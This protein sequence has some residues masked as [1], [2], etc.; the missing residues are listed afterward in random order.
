MTIALGIIATDGLVMAADTQQTIQGYAKFNRGKMGASLVSGLGRPNAHSG[1]VIAGAGTSAHL[2]ALSRNLQA[3]FNGPARLKSMEET[4]DA[5]AEVVEQ[6]HKR[7]VLPYAAFPDE[8]PDVKVLIGV[9]KDSNVKLFVSQGNLLKPADPYEAVGVGEVLAR[10][11]LQ[12][13]FQ[14]PMLDVWETVL[15]ASYVMYLVKESV[16]GC[17]GQTDMMCLYHKH[18]SFVLVSR[19]QT[20]EIE[21]IF[22]D[23]CCGV[24]PANFRSVI[25][26]AKAN[27]GVKASVVRR[28][29]EK[30]IALLK[31]AVA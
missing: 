24:E 22:S 15:L 11:F 12:R 8:R 14:M 1:C 7:Y 28:R 16:D 31:R 17:G 3:K 13:F 30:Q 19:Q 23:Y 29:L 9:L 21:R 2:G 20:K 10:T 5:F 6:F 27:R 4:Q 26:A 18:P 25:G